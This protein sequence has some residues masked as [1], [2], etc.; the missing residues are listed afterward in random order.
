M[1]SAS[2]LALA[3]LLFSIPASAVTRLVPSVY[4]TIQ[5]AI[6]AS[7]PG[8]VVQVA[9][10]IYND[11]I[12]PSSP[13]DTTKCVAVMRSG[14]SLIGS[15]AGATIID[16][17]DLGSGHVGR[18]I[19]C[20]GVT[21][22]TIAGLT[23]RSAFAAVYGA[24]I[25]CTDGSSPTIR[26]IEVRECR[27]GGI[28]INHDSSPT[29]TNSVLTSNIAKEGGGIAVINGSS[30][31]ITACIIKENRAPT[32]GGVFSRTNC[33]VTF[34]YCDISDNSILTVVGAG[35]GGSFDSMNLLMENC[36]INGNSA[37]TGGGGLYIARCN[38]AIVRN[39]LIQG[40][41]VEND[42]YG[43]GGGIWLDDGTQA[44]IEDC[45]ITHN[46]I[47]NNLF[48][49]NGGGVAI[50]WAGSST[51]LRQCTIA[52]NHSPT[53]LGAG[54]WCAGTEATI[55]KC[56]VAFNTGGDGLYCGEFGPYPTTGCSN[57]YG[58]ELGD[59][60]CGND[61]GHNFSLD[62][63]FCDLGADDY[64]LQ[65][66]SPC[67]A[68]GHPEGPSA[69]NGS[70]IGGEDIGCA[71]VSIDLEPVAASPRQLRNQPNP[72]SG[73]TNLRFELARAGQVSLRIYDAAGRQVRELLNGPMN[74]GPAQ[75]NW[76]GRDET[77]LALPSG[78]Y[79]CRLTADGVETARPIALT[80]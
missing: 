28:I 23:I 44:T 8:D 12:H 65:S 47:L 15:G 25:Y 46:A 45:T 60:I 13:S 6:D 9:P 22:A 50:L 62:P 80:R 52:N 72:F 63:V 58:N 74:A 21:N 73:S 32:G 36:I 68:G 2:A 69:C 59:A 31:V 41:L 78:V 20:S 39:C 7:S 61:A 27:D 64:R 76:D 14:V 34:S 38:S 42:D 4:P 5:A 40:N 30:A 66:T 37:P 1:R 16:C 49:C 11:C 71:P 33:D 48:D 26:D 67:R 19:Y 18:G 77:G 35:G 3:L 43:P 54:I 24:G 29:I 56:I 57:F 75:I 55:E 10:G 51:I 17:D 53:G 79:F 70:R